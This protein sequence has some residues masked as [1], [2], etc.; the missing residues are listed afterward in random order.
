MVTAAKEVL[1]PNKSVSI[2]IRVHKDIE[3]TVRLVRA[4][5]EA[6]VDFVTVHART[7]NQRSS[8]PP[9]LVALKTLKNHFPTLPMLANGDVYSVQ[10]AAKIVAETGVEG[11]MAA[12]GILENPALFAGYDETPREA[13][14]MFMAHAVSTGIRFEL[15]VHHLGDMMGKM[16]T[17][18]ERRGLTECRDLVDLSDWLDEQWDFQRHTSGVY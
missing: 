2:K 1:G 5:Q 14:E 10:D 13:I 15:V 7:K 18:K 11:V 12:R 17:K 8:T 6:G 4:A 16:T 9:D 3:E